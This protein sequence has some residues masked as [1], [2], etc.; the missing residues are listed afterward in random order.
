MFAR[1]DH[2]SFDDVEF[3]AGRFTGRSHDEFALEF[4]ADEDQFRSD[5]H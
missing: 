3:I 1:Q 5:L 2:V 4:L